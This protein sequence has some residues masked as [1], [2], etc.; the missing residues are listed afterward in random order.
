MLWGE[1]SGICGFDGAPA[2]SGCLSDLLLQSWLM[3]STRSFGVKAP[4]HGAKGIP[5]CQRARWRDRLFHGAKAT[6][7]V[8]PD[9]RI[10]ML[11]GVIGQR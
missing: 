4:R 9:Q 2:D 8:L 5:W 1:S 3:G 6:E 11:D 10:L 7:L